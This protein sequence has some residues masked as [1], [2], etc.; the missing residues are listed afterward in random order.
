MEH[1]RYGV[2]GTYNRLVLKFIE[3][4]AS[5]EKKMDGHFD[6]GDYYD[7][8]LELIVLLDREEKQCSHK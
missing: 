1:W 2:P 6:P 8:I 4:D 5:G 7:L 3:D